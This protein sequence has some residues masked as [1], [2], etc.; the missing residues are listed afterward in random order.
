MK[1]K[2]ILIFLIFS[3]FSLTVFAHQ[4]FWVV[5]EFGNIKTR[6]KT[7]YQYE[8]IKKVEIIGKLAE[9]LA[10]E[11]NYN[12]PVLLD[13][14]HFYV[15]IAKPTYFLSFDRG[16]IN[17]NSSNKENGIKLL[18]KNGI[19]IRQVSNTFNI[20]NTLKIL[21]YSINNWKSI[22]KEQKTIEYK[23]NY[24][25]WLINS[26]NKTKILNILNNNESETLK[27]IKK[28]KI[29]RPESKLKFSLNY[30]WK[31]GKYHI[32]YRENNK[33]KIILSINSIYSIQ[34]EWNTIFIFETK[35]KFLVIDN[36]NKELISKKWNI[37]N[38]NQ[39]YRPYKIERLGG[40]KYVIKFSFF[41]EET[42]EQNRILIYSKNNDK[43]IQDLDKLM[44][45]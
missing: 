4:D 8:E 26:I 6:I 15:G 21:E 30:F 2:N 13:F 14:N 35:T 10:K 39:N 19:V 43:L 24:C 3:L 40:D 12:K 5:K 31:N 25:D 1:T 16:K 37:E 23:E 22:E 11:L 7:G 32:F 33:E 18:D 29:Y 45:N 36:N 38:G 17:Y 9:M 34:K 41:S 42:G 27:K 20:L 44:R 28:L